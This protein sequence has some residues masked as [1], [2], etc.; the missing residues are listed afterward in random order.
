MIFNIILRRSALSEQSLSASSTETI[1]ALYEQH[2]DMLVDHLSRI[3]IY[4][5]RL[6][7]VE[8]RLDYAIRSKLS[9]K[10]NVPLFYVCLKVKEGEGADGGEVKDVM[11]LAGL[12][13]MHD[14]LA[15][16]NQYLLIIQFYIRS[17]IWFCSRLAR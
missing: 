15:K 10:E 12:E 1:L 16:V 9:G 11:F 6:V 4:L 17:V 8:W 5:P 2:G 14:L 13:E 7:G 3:G